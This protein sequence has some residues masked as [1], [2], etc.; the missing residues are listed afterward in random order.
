MHWYSH[1][2]PQMLLPLTDIHPSYLFHQ[3][4]V[5]LLPNSELFNAQTKQAFRIVSQ[6]TEIVQH[7]SDKICIFITELIVNDSRVGP[8]ICNVNCRVDHKSS[9][10]GTV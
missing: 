10:N 5:F 1:L 9:T 3:L 7:E 8:L 6:P 2:L 4:L